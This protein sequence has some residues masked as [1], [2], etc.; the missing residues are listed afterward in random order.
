MPCRGWCS[1]IALRRHATR[2][3]APALPRRVEPPEPASPSGRPLHPPGRPLHPPSRLPAVRRHSCAC[4]C[5]QLERSRH[6]HCR[7]L[8]LRLAGHAPLRPSVTPSCAR[9]PRR[10]RL[11]SR[12]CLAA[13]RRRTGRTYWWAW[14]A[15]WRAR[16]RRTRPSRSRVSPRM[17]SR[18]SG[19]WR[20]A[21][22]EA[23]P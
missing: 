18:V 23:S 10:P 6:G 17:P 9:A 2:A 12:T 5:A 1:E 22:R 19:A 15:A 8:L 20:R 4:V 11:T 7:N 16:A 14:A 13:T 21:P 3:V